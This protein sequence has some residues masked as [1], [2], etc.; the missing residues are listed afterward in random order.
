MK[1]DATWRRVAVPNVACTPC[2]KDIYLSRKAARSQRRRIHADGSLHVYRCPNNP[3]FWHLGTTDQLPTNSEEPDTVTFT[4]APTVPTFDVEDVFPQEPPMD[5][6]TAL[7]NRLM[8]D[9]STYRF[10][11]QVE[12]T[13]S[14]ARRLIALNAENNRVKQERLVERYARDMEAFNPVTGKRNWREKTGQVIQ[15]ATDGTVINGQHRLHAVVKSGQTIRFDLCFGVDPRDIVVVDAHKGRSTNDIIRVS[16]GRDLSGVG[17]IVRWVL[18]WERG[19]YTG[20]S[21]NFTP[22][23]VEIQSRFEQAPE[24]FAAA[25]ARGKDCQNRN[26]APQRVAGMAYYLLREIDKGEADDFFDQFVSGLGLT[27]RSAI[28]RLRERMIRRRIEKLTAHHQLALVIKAWNRH[29][30]W[31]PS[32]DIDERGPD[33]DN[34]VREPVSR[35]QAVGEGEPNNANFPLPIKPK[36]FNANFPLPIKPKYFG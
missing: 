3:N 36:Y 15:I 34:L 33:G 26:L 17:A 13:P 21:G 5:A 10:V 2:R 32:G 4:E 6:T 30:T 18:A 25:S 28:Y 9:L 11:P 14:L 8:A 35:L 24:L 7:L 22:T 20:T 23:P 1:S 19:Q 29:H 31:V 16:G 12:V 27:D